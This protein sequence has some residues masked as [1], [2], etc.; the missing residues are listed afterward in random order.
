MFLSNFLYSTLRQFWIQRISRCL[1]SINLHN[2]CENQYF[3]VKECGN[4][5]WKGKSHIKSNNVQLMRRFFLQRKLCVY[6][7]EGLGKVF[8]LLCTKYKYRACFFKKRILGMEGGKLQQGRQSS[9]SLLSDRRN[10]QQGG[11]PRL[12]SAKRQVCSFNCRRNRPR[13]HPQH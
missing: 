9:S 8:F 7:C 6:V 11:P 10:R 13:G 2:P 12:L 1:N 5:G 3:C 4:K